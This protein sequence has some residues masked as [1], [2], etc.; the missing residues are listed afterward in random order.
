MAETGNEL[1]NDLTWD[2][3]SDVTYDFRKAMS[4]TWGLLSFLSEAKE[5]PESI[6]YCGSPCTCCCVKESAIPS[7]SLRPELPNAWLDTLRKVAK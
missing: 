5:G 2:L 7:A 4:L 3:S 6:R 1:E